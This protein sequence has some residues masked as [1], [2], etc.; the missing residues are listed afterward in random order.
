MKVDELIEMLEIIRHS[1]EPIQTPDSNCGYSTLVKNVKCDDS[2]IWVIDEAI[3][4]LIKA[5][6]TMNLISNASVTDDCIS[7]SALKEEASNLMG[8]VGSGMSPTMLI[9]NE[10]LNLIDNAPTWEG[11]SK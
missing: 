10:V 5:K 6:D 9:R 2:F 11:E 8:Y 7:R 4:E 1:A 3:K